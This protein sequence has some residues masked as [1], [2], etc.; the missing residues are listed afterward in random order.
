AWSDAIDV[1]V[2]H[3]SGTLGASTL[4]DRD[5]E[6][7]ASLIESYPHWVTPKLADYAERP[8]ALPAGPADLLH[9]LRD[10]PILLGNARRDV[11]SDPFGAF[12]EASRVWGSSF[13]A[14]RP[15]DFRPTDDKAYWLRP[16]THG[17]VKEDWD[18][19]LDFIDANIGAG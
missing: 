15:D 19:F 6:P 4:A 14:L 7:L 17:V 11:W 3:Q 12:K 5:G 2:A 9:L 10:K 1:V 13:T 8:G 16:G 18:A